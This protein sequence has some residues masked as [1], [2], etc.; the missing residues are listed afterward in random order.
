MTYL[1]DYSQHGCGEHAVYL[2]HQ[3][4]ALQTGEVIELADAGERYTKCRE[5]LGSKKHF[6][7]W[8]ETMGLSIETAYRAIRAV[9]V[10]GADRL[11][12]LLVCRS[13]IY[14]LCKK[15]IPADV[16]EAILQKAEEES[17]SLLEVKKRVNVDTTDFDAKPPAGVDEGVPDIEP[18]A[19]FDGY[20]AEKEPPPETPRVW[21]VEFLELWQEAD[22]IG[23]AGILALLREEGYAIYEPGQSP[24]V[25]EMAKRPERLNRATQIDRGWSTFWH[26]VH[27]KVGKGGAKKAFGKAVERLEVEGYTLPE[28]ISYLCQRMVLFARS[29]QAQHEVTGKLHAARWLNE[30]RYHD[31]EKAW[32][33]EA[34]QDTPATRKIQNAQL[35]IE[36]FTEDETI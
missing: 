6:R 23:K 26:V 30:E 1:F 19:D 20:P 7:A 27:R 34:P 11:K 12:R 18:N 28:A 24:L 15:T 4:A 25:E 33:E 2:E 21:A 3:A 5:L 36:Q 29:P 13:A 8:V 10:I 16:R 35:A 14:E 9:E 22:E 17:I 32:N 31:D